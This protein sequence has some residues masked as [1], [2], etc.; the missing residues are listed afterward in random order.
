MVKKAET[1]KQKSFEETLWDSAN[2]L[3]GNAILFYLESLC[4][5]G[6][7]RVT[8]QITFLIMVSTR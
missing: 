8:R 2:K 5:L 3:R 6:E 7:M 4:L 1:K